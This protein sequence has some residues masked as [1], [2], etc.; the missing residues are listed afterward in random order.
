MDTSNIIDTMVKL[1]S[2]NKRPI[3]VEVESDYKLV[4]EAPNGSQLNRLFHRTFERPNGFYLIRKESA[5]R[6][7]FKILDNDNDSMYFFMN[8]FSFLYTMFLGSSF[9]TYVFFKPVNYY[10]TLNVAYVRKDLRA[11][12]KFNLIKK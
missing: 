9:F 6:D 7:L 3:F 4:A 10:E 12:E 2:T 8:R 1:E 11:A 5:S